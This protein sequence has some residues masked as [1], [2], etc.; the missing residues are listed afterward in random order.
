MDLRRRSA[1]WILSLIHISGSMTVLLGRLFAGGTGF[2]DVGAS[3]TQPIFK[4][5]TLLHRERAAKDAYIEAS[6]QYRSTVLTAFENVA[7]TLL[8]L[9]HI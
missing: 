6:E 9:I 2:W 1:A 8:S 7:D 5:G 3:V 4:G